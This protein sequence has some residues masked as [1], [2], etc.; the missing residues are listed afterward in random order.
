MAQVTRNLTDP[1][2]GVLRGTRFL[3]LDRDSKFSAQFRRTI[4]NAGIEVIRTA[5]NA[6]NMNAFAESPSASCGSIKSEC[7]DKM[8]FFGEPSLQRAITEYVAH[9]HAER[10]HQGIG[11]VADPTRRPCARWLS[12][13]TQDQPRRTAESI[14]IARQPDWLLR[15]KRKQLALD[16][17]S[18]PV[19]ALSSIH[20]PAPGDL[21]GQ[22]RLRLMT[23]AFGSSDSTPAETLFLL[24]FPV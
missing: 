18:P 24:L 1:F 23:A 13:S 20:V 14:I 11:N 7:L 10:P 21:L 16:H 12:C 17:L 8:V 5:V 9:Y 19:D 6:P 4:I 3:I 22:P 15:R 2:D